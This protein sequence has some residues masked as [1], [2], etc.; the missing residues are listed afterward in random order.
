[1][2]IRLTRLTLLIVAGTFATI[3]IILAPDLQW[4]LPDWVR[5]RRV[6][7]ALLGVGVL[8]LA[9]GFVVRHHRGGSTK[10]GLR[11]R[12]LQVADARAQRAISGGL[13]MLFILASLSFLTTWLPHYLL[14]PWAR[15]A[16]TF[17]TLAQSWDAGILPY[18]DIRGYN[19]PGAI[20]L[21]WLLGK[22][23]GWGQ[24]WALHAFDAASL[25][26]LGAILTAWSRR[27]LGRAVPGLAAYLVFLTFYLSRDFETVSQ[28]D[29]HASLCIVLALLIL[30][31]WPGRTS[32]L[33]SAL[34]AAAGLAIRPHVLLFLPAIAAAVLEAEDRPRWRGL[35]AWF[36]GFLTFGT[37]AFAPLVWAGIA[38]DLVRG[39]QVAAYGGP[40][41]QATATSA[42]AALA[43]QLG[44]SSTWVAIVGLA[45]VFA[46]T[47]G[48]SRRRAAT[49]TLALGA[50]LA[51]RL[52][53]PVQH[54]YL[55]QPLDLVRSVGLALPIAWVIEREGAPAPMRLV[56]T[57]ILTV[58]MSAGLPR[59]CDPAASAE[60]VR[61][62]ARGESPPLRSPPGSRAWFDPASA[63]WYAWED[64]RDT[65]I[66]LRRNTDPRTLVANV[67][68]EPPYPAIN[69][70]AGRLSPFRAESGI[71]WMLLVAVD[72]ERGVRQGARTGDRL[73][74]RL[75]ARGVP[76]SLAAATA[77]VSRGD[78]GRVPARGAIR[79]HRGLAPVRSSRRLSGATGGPVVEDT[80]ARGPQ[81][82]S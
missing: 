67:L 43:D 80:C 74:R 12:V 76:A 56:A 11:T 47:R 39:L 38:D 34:L 53:H 82:R 65:L 30:E 62:I 21:C 79:A 16:D 81:P 40:Y 52:V 61:S 37:I 24:T 57:L 41:S 69:G 32:R 33:L 25:I 36:V 60:A 77:P 13:T 23:C 73:R 3:V 5:R 45:L 46:T 8:Y 31:G 58:E 51:Y 64:Y 22:T 26:A 14:W 55:A 7:A 28:R 48:A 6:E 18:R 2:T 10:D 1:M 50:A 4:F 27:R 68:Q 54:G 44:Q 35:V 75:V 72:L 9:W 19:F 17:A 59:F 70:P 49:W 66:Y 78:P 63:R 20:Y 42:L 15:D 29:G 71:C